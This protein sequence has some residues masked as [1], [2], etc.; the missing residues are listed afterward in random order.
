MTKEVDLHEDMASH[1]VAIKKFKN[2]KSSLKLGMYI[3]Y[4]FQFLKIFISY[5]S[6]E[7]F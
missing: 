6:N 7:V 5:N 3:S 2:Y 4:P 1:D